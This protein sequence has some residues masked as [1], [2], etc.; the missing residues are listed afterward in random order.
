M[1]ENNCK[2]K[3]HKTCFGTTSSLMR[4]LMLLGLNVLV[5]ISAPAR[6]QSR[7][8]YCA[9]RL[10]FERA[11]PASSSP[12]TRYVNAAY[13]YSVG[14]PA[15][16][17]VLTR[18]EGPER[19]FFLALTETPR[20]YLR[21][22]AAYD[23]FYGITPDGVHR[24]DLNAIRLHDAV[25]GEESEAAQLAGEPALRSVVRLRCRGSLATVVHET[26]IA[27]RRREIYRLDL[28]STAERFPT[29]ERLLES[30]WRSWRWETVR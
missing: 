25:L 13:G 2:I 16:Q 6:A 15:G 9:E 19:G 10:P 22:D 27:V 4:L 11:Q 21:V 3:A 17:S 26:L 1:S 5:A 18:G 20:G 29:D 14:I 12:G 30:L 7:E 28:Q 24:R 8:D 23:V